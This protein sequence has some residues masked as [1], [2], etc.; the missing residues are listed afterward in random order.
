MVK[1][2]DAHE[3]LQTMNEDPRPQ[4]TYLAFVLR[5]VA[6]KA[7]RL[8][9]WAAR[10]TA[11]VVIV[12]VV[13]PAGRWV[14]HKLTVLS[15]QRH[16]ESRRAP[17][18]VA[19]NQGVAAS[20]PDNRIAP[21]PTIPAVMPSAAAIVVVPRRRVTPRE[22]EA[23]PAMPTPVAPS[24]RAVLVSI[25]EGTAI[26]VALAEE[27]ATDRNSPGDGFKAVLVDDLVSDGHVIARAQTEVRGRIT[28]MRRGSRSENPTITLQLDS[29]EG[30]NGRLSLSTAPLTIEG[31]RQSKV[32]KILRG[33]GGAVA[34]A[35]VGGQLDGK[36]GAVLG[37]GLGT[38][39]AM[40][41]DSLSLPPASVSRFQLSRNV[42]L[43]LPQ[44]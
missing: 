41:G 9:I 23:A 37:A 15:T 4:D 13:P 17:S 38:V 29:L 26:T 16:E 34:G 7:R 18:A 2:T 20:V 11:F 36:K 40:K 5:P 8:A 10:I 44:Q 22:L 30:T 12:L 24:P 32:K 19:A 31:K 43:N 25:P 39:V 1:S 33:V 28:D 35:V 6:A 3:A 21:P 27:I 42:A 14:S